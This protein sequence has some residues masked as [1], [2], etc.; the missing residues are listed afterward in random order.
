MDLW[1]LVRPRRRASIFAFVA[2]CFLFINVCFANHG[3]GTSGGGSSTASGETLKPGAFDLS[4]NVNY[5]KFESISRNEA[6]QRAIVSGGFDALDDAALTTLSVGYGIIENLQVSGSIGYYWGNNFV[7]AEPDGLGGAESGVADPQGLTDLTLA[8][9]YRFMQGA[10]GNIAVIAGAILPTGRN[11]VLLDT[12]ERLEPSS[13]PGTGQYGFLAGLAYS[14]FLTSHLTID[15][16]GIYSQH[17]ERND[18]Q[19]GQRVDL[20]AALAYRLTNSIKSFPNF[21]VFGEANAVWLGKDLNDG[22]INLNSG[23]WTVYLTP[24]GRVR[25]N[26]HLSLTVAPSFPV[27]QDLNGDQIKVEYKLSASLEASF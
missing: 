7:D 3:P 13:Q 26:D 10:P 4:L 23:G 11:D 21:S 9:K 22:E 5:T 27:M 14:R 12:G 24:G 25:F 19:V 20:G 2:S 16:S 17:F 6:E 8:G 18:F 15:G 1:L